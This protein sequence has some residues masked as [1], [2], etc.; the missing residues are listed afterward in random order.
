MLYSLNYGLTLRLRIDFFVGYLRM[1]PISKKASTSDTTSANTIFLRN[2]E[3]GAV[4]S[5]HLHLD[6]AE[7]CHRLAP[8]AT[9]SSLAG[10]SRNL[11]VTPTWPALWKM[12]A[13]VLIY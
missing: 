2:K 11:G 8:S 7:R 3:N 1:V 9:K 10:A 13:D 12:V 4:S 6:N 5:K